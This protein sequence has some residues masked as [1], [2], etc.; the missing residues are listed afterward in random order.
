LIIIIFLKKK[1]IIILSE[2]RNDGLIL[3]DKINDKNIEIFNLSEE[4]S[5]KLIFNANGGISSNSSFCWWSIF[6]SENRNW[7]MP[8]QWL[9]KETIFDNN[10]QID[11]TLVI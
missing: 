3:K 5:F 1:K 9:K 10:L 6:L 11:K 8:F 2:D 7:I 4:D